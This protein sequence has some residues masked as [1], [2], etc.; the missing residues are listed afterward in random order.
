[1]TAPRHRIG[2]PDADALEDA[3]MPPGFYPGRWTAP[4]TAA[5]YA[6]AHGETIAAGPSLD[7]PDP[8]HAPEEA[9]DLPATVAREHTVEERAEPIG[10]PIGD[11]P[12]AAVPLRAPARFSSSDSASGGSSSG[13]IR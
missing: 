4:L 9:H 5:D 3:G 13:V 10:R 12:N 11:T 6:R 8:E 2:H 7:R 1:M